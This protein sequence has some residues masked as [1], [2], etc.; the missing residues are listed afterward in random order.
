M[1]TLEDTLEE[2]LGGPDID[3]GAFFKMA[4]GDDHEVGFSLGL[5]FDTFIKSQIDAKFNANRAETRQKNFMRDISDKIEILR[6]RSETDDIDIKEIEDAYR[7][8]LAKLISLLEEKFD[9]DFSEE[10]EMLPENTN[11]QKLGLWATELYTFLIIERMDMIIEFLTNY[12]FLNKGE[13]AKEFSSK[14]VSESI[15]KSISDKDGVIVIMSIMDIIANVARDGV[16]FS[17]FIEA[18]KNGREG[19]VSVEIASKTFN[20]DDGDIVRLYLSPLIEDEE[21]LSIVASRVRM[22]L[23]QMLTKE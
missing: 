10:T 19:E 16:P 3:E 2:S 14:K 5:V 4:E 9:F 18:I 22:E 7:S 8:I 1:N 6:V 13:I 17:E 20:G 23:F 12:I 15:S 21:L 11:T